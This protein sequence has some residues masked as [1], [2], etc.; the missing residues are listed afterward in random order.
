MIVIGLTGGIASGKSTAAVQLQARGA[1]RIDA[2]ALAHRVYQPGSEAHASVVEAFGPE[3]VA[4]DG[5]IDRSALGQS[6]FGLP[7]KLEQALGRGGKRVFETDRTKWRREL[8][9]VG[10]E[11]ILL[12]RKDGESP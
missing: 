6:V 12:V 2:D 8:R 5:S 4:A 1:H 9:G 7:E 11:Q 10:G 3:V